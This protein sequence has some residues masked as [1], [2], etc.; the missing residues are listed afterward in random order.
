MIGILR[1][2][3]IDVIIIKKFTIY[4]SLKFL[5]YFGIRGYIVFCEQKNE[6]VYSSEYIFSVIGHNYTWFYMAG[7]FYIRITIYY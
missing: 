2:N 7:N 6:L 1:A 3:Y 4:N 5:G